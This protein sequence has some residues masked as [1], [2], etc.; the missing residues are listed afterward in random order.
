MNTRLKVGLVGCGSVSQRGILP[1][2]AQEDARGR[3]ELVAVCDVVRERASEIMRR[4]GA[5]EYYTDLGEMLKRA[6]IELVLIATP[7]PFHFENAMAALLMNKHVY[8]QKTIATTVAEANAIVEE[9]R[10]RDLKLVASPGQMLSPTLQRIKGL[11]EEGVIGKVYWAFT[12]NNAPGHESEPFREDQDILSDVDPTWYY[13][14]GGGP[15]YDMT[16]YSLH[17]LTGLLGPAKRVTSLSGRREEQRYWK[18]KVIQVQVDDNT[19]MLLD[20]G[21][22]IFAIAGGS[23]CQFGPRIWWGHLSIF[24]AEGAIETL[25]IE[26][27][28]GLPTQVILM[29]NG[30]LKERLGFPWGFYTSLGPA[31]PL[32][33]VQGSHLWIEE[34][35]VYADIMHLVDCILED[36]EPIASGEHAAHVVEIIEKTYLAAK[37]GESQEIS[38][39]F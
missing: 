15:V 26:P 24:G 4:F 39:T 2:L 20:F 5:K 3:V 29:S 34:A 36:R 11:L 9:A 12:A 27:Q 10:R 31:G 17:T 37:T 35:Q 19:L 30:V 14:A 38:T 7:I 23:N 33:H 22:S 18:D 21:D 8:V 16:V 13:K 1:H 28:T 32:P 25:A 6:D